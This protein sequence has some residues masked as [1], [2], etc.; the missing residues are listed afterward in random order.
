MRESLAAS[1]AQQLIERQL[2]NADK[3]LGRES[4]AR[5]ARRNVTAYDLALLNLE[6][7]FEVSRIIDTLGRELAAATGFDYRGLDGS[8]APFPDGETSVAKVVELLGPSPVVTR[9]TMISV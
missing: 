5:P 4:T 2:A 1:A 3:A 6:S 9:V 8:L 7:K